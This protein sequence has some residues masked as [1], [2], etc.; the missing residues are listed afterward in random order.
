MQLQTILNRV[1][2][3]KSFVYGEP[4]WKDDALRLTIEVP[5]R[6]AGQRPAGLLGLRQAAARLRSAGVSGASSSCR[7]G[8]SPWCSSMPCD[9]SIV[10]AAAW[11]SNAFPGRPANRG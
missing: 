8:R 10:R 9:A 1:E 3:H 11:W 5:I 2:R 6:S 7:C 4:R